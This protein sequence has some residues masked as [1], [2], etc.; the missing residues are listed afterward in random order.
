MRVNLSNYYYY[1]YVYIIIVVVVGLKIV[2]PNIFCIFFFLFFILFSAYFTNCC[3]CFLL[4]RVEFKSR[5][6]IFNFFFFL[7]LCALLFHS[8]FILS[9]FF[10]YLQRTGHSGGREGSLVALNLALGKVRGAN[11]HLV[12]RICFIVKL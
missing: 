4:L 2:L 6:F 10:V 3:R 1:F 12:N 8:S 11:Q 7:V 9:G 5:L